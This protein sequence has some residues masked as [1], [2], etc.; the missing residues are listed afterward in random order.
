MAPAG[1]HLNRVNE[2]QRIASPRS[3]RDWTR[4]EDYVD[5][6]ARRRSFRRTHRE[7]IRTEAERPRLLL[8]TVPFLALTS[9]LAVLAV[10]IAVAAFPGTQ[11]QFKSPPPPVKQQGWANPGWLQEAKKDFHH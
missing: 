4:A 6:L 11:P 5:A 2:Q 10:A 1:A 9:F 8:S 3:R 7:K